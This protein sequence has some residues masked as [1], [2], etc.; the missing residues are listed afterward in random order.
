MKLGLV[1]KIEDSL[2]I[3]SLDKMK[4]HHLKVFHF[5]LEND[6]V[7][8]RLTLLIQDITDYLFT[9]CN[10]LKAYILNIRRSYVHGVVL[11]SIGEGLTS[12]STTLKTL[13]VS[14]DSKAESSCECVKAFTDG[15]EKQSKNLES[16]LL[17]MGN[18]PNDLN[19]LFTKLFHSEF[20]SL[21][22]L[23]LH[24][25][26]PCKDVGYDYYQELLERLGSRPIS[27]EP[28]PN[29]PIFEEVLCRNLKKL[30]RL[31]LVL[32]YYKRDYA[33]QEQAV[34]NLINSNLSTLKH[35]EIYYDSPDSRKFISQNIFLQNA[36]NLVHLRLNMY[37]DSKNIGIL[38]NK[39]IH[40]STQLEY[41]D[42]TFNGRYNH[43]M[44]FTDD[45]T[46]EAFNEVCKL[47]RAKIWSL[48]V[49]KVKFFTFKNKLTASHLEILRE[50]LR[51]NLQK[52]D[53]L[54]ISLSGAV[55]LTRNEA[56][57]MTEVLKGMS[58]QHLT[59][60]I[61]KEYYRETLIGWV[62]EKNQ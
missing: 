45:L 11:K 33:K 41:L 44:E 23:D 19:I 8:S 13:K 2:D 38:T 59:Y 30:E 58:N 14:F 55:P 3:E 39:L 37:M 52:L 49:L 1:Y 53:Y 48:K 16:L 29:L 47:I 10:K 32:Y 34:C 7:D 31:R 15:I 40:N 56:D 6:E 62:A 9:N 4:F 35:L 42:L 21:K 36:L 20:S 60:L 25:K 51:L 27:K 18:L 46:T 43:D 5:D 24:L 57:T 26:E 50:S 22:F 61:Y 17:K 28:E 54:E 12:S